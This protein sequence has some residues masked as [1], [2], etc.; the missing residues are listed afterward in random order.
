M[1]KTLDRINNI[2]CYL[3]LFIKEEIKQQN[4]ICRKIAANLNLRLIE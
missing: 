2:S 1:K 4:K 3:D